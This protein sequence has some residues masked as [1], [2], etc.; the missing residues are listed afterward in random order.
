MI[1]THIAEGVWEICL[2]RPAKRNALSKAMYERLGDIVDAAGAAPDCAALVLYGAGGAFSAGADIEDFRTRRDHED[3]PAV[4]F[5]RKLARTDVPTIAAV[6]GFAIGIGATLLQHFDFVYATAQ[7]RFHMPFVALGLC[8]EAGSSLL[9]ERQVGARRA[10]DWLLR[11]RPF[12]GRAALEAG[13]VTALAEPGAVLQAARDCAADLARQPLAS[14]RASKALLRRGGEAELMAA[15][16]A[17]VR[18]FADLL[19][20]D[21]TQAIF[22]AFL[23]RRA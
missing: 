12:D 5:L 4:R 10:R 22:S 21:S 6:E 19:N 1:R 20:S 18:T 2:D 7:T 17:E 9:L 14:V 11:G 3:S 16:D 15:L 8:P 23:E 13:F